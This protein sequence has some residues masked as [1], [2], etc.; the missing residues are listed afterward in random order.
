MDFKGF[1]GFLRIS[2]GISQAFQVATVRCCST[3]PSCVPIRG[4]LKVWGMN[5]IH[6]LRNIGHGLIPMARLFLMAC[7]MDYF[8][9]ID[10]IEC[11]SHE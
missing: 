7:V 11:S 1:R 4:G 9:L 3:Q 5:L 6:G 10:G 2:S 8:L